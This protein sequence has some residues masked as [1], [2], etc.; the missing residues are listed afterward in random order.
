VEEGNQDATKV[1]TPT[2]Q[3]AYFYQA[4]E[5]AMSKEQQSLPKPVGSTKQGDLVASTKI[6]PES[7][8][9]L[10]QFLPD[11]IPS[12]KMHPVSP[13]TFGTTTERP[14]NTVARPRAPG[15]PFHSAPASAPTCGNT[16]TIPTTPKRSADEAFDSKDSNNKNRTD[17]LQFRL[18]R[19]QATLGVAD[20]RAVEMHSNFDKNDARRLQAGFDKAKAVHKLVEVQI[21]LKEAEGSSKDEPEFLKL[22]TRRAEANLALV[23]AEENLRSF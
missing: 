18:R 20:A 10:L 17:H 7:A 2:P 19:A 12:F 13:V 9:A 14:V 3:A 16:R 6:K 23:E 5:K 8:V 1:T 11:P 22:L 21:E 4:A 15:F